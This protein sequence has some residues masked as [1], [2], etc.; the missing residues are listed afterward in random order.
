MKRF[1]FVAEEAAQF[2]VSLLCKSLGVTRQGYYAW[3]RRE[4]SARELADRELSPCC[5]PVASFSVHSP[6]L[7]PRQACVSVLADR[8]FR[9]HAVRDRRSQASS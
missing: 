2:P 1:R 9:S 8:V 5:V 4:P 7:A 6:A 3:K